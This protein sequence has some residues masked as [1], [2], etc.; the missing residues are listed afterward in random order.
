MDLP[1]PNALLDRL[2]EALAKTLTA[3]GI[4]EPRVVGI[5]TGGVWVA[6]ELARRLGWSDPIGVLDISFH[7]D[8]FGHA[9]LNPAV[10][11]SNLPWE[12]DGRDLVLVDDVLYTGRTVRAALNEIFDWGRPAKVVLAALVER[13]G[14]ELPVAADAVGARVEVGSGRLL[15]LRGPEPLTLAIT[16]GRA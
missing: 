3:R 14:R 10:H 5:H 12:I 8:D 6:R 13:D 2:A 16:E 9:G 11:P 7:R 4:T 15:K 1:D